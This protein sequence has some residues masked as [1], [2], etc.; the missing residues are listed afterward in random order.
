MKKKGSLADPIV[1]VITTFITVVFLGIMVYMFSEINT[2]LE[3]NANIYTSI[4]GVHITQDGTLGNGEF[5]DV[6]RGIDW[7]TTRIQ[8]LVFMELINNDKIAYTNAGIQLVVSKVKA[9]LQEGVDRGL[10][11]E[12]GEDAVSA[13]NVEDISD[14][15]KGNRLLPDI[16]WT[17]ELAGA[18]HETQI[19][20]TITL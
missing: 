6:T 18:I 15:A 20:G 2:A 8:Q 4:A 11:R 7:L 5:I 12:L 16:N 1:W 3:K 17:V 9:A 14:T 10:L 19:N 13:P